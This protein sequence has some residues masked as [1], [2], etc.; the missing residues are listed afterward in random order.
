MRARH[1]P[2]GVTE[3]TPLL[4]LPPEEGAT[5]ANSGATMVLPSQTPLPRR[6]VL[7]AFLAVLAA[8]AGLVVGADYLDADDGMYTHR[9]LIYA[10]SASAPSG[11]AILTGVILDASG[12]PL[13][14]HTVTVLADSRQVQARTDPHGNFRLEGLDPGVAILD[15]DSPDRVE[16][17]RNRVLLSPPAAFE[18]IGF[19]HLTLR[20]PSDANFDEANASTGHRWVDLSRSQQENSTEPYDL[21]AGAMY[22]MFGTAFVG[23]GAL[24]VCLSGAG[25]RARNT[26]LIRLGAVAGF[27]SMGHL[28]TGCGLGMLALLL[29]IALPRRD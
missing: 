23:L 5:F 7:A 26:G 21:A 19:T 20:W 16:M 6:A 29:T 27:L 28:Y 11:S 13:F 24:A 14:N 9:Q 12:E 4:S 2:D 15:I 10:Q 22:D 18:P 3:E 17:L 25:L 8:C 1:H